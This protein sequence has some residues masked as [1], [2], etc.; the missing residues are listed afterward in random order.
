LVKASTFSQV[1]ECECLG[2][3]RRSEIIFAPCS[4]CRE[5]ASTLQA[6]VQ[7]RRACLPPP[8]QSGRFLLQLAR[9]ERKRSWLTSPR[10]RLTEGLP[11]PVSSQAPFRS[12]Q[13]FQ[14]Q[15][16]HIGLSRSRAY[17]AMF[18]ASVWRGPVSASEPPSR[19]YE[20][21]VVRR[22]G[23]IC[24]L[25]PLLETPDDTLSLCPLSLLPAAA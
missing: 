12:R 6:S 9:E 11:Q 1:I 15:T 18:E 7:P 25:R 5:R 19:V 3:Q 22:A 16:Y 4:A 14:C 21:G 13:L 10:S 8:A 20:S 17:R 24:F 2:P 23:S